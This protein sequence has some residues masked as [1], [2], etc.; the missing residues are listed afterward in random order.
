M[1]FELY[2]AQ[3][4]NAVTPGR[5]SIDSV[6]HLHVCVLDLNAVRI[7]G[8]AVILID[9]GTH[10]LAIRAPKPDQKEPSVNCRIGK[11][12]RSG[13]IGLAGALKQI[14]RAE[15]HGRF[16]VTRKDDLLIVEFD[17]EPASSAKPI[18]GRSKR[19]K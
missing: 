2:M 12:R 13:I 8:E 1:S 5:C 16:A 15:T 19:V 7:D 9:P 14:G 10:R 4:K 17:E 11:S 18:D 3:R 6:G